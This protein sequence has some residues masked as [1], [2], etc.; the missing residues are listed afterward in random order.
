MD[1]VADRALVIAANAWNLLLVGLFLARAARAARL[2]RRL[3]L[4]A[5]ALILPIGAV[6]FANAL[7]RRPWWATLLPALIAAYLFLELLLDYLL[8]L[9]FRQTRALGPYLLLFYAAQWAAIGYAFAVGRAAG[10]VT[11][12]T[13]FLCLGATAYSYARAGHG[14][15]GPPSPPAAARR[16]T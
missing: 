10:F 11:L 13:Y 8:G 15:S 7:A 9:N 3:G 12:A 2:E 6:G 16:A 1:W 4:A 5:V 14:E